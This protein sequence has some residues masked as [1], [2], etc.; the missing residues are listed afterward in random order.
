MKRTE[1]ERTIRYYDDLI[2]ECRG[3]WIKAKG[4]LEKRR[5]MR[6]IDKGLD[7]RVILMG[8]RD[9]AEQ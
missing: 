2:S 5:Y 3:L 1:Y 6:L 7:T 4:F 8:L 9:V